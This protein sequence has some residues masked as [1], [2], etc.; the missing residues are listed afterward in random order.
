ML[1]ILESK[2]IALLWLWNGKGYCN[3]RIFKRYL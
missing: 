1:P 3:H 2:V